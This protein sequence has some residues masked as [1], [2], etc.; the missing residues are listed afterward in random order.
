MNATSDSP[1]GRSLPPQ[2]A[3]ESDVTRSDRA[4]GLPTEAG[5]YP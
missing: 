2:R 5:E 4:G 3:V 1:T